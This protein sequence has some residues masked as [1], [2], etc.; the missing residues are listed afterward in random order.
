MF[1]KCKYSAQVYFFNI[2]MK[3]HLC[4]KMENVSKLIFENTVKTSTILAFTH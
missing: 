3:V 2:N 4:Q 1:R